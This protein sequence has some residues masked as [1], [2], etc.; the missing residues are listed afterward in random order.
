MGRN[1]TVIFGGLV[2]MLIGL[3]VLGIVVD[4]A[5]DTGAKA[6]IG[7]FTGV[8]S[9]ND[10]APLVFAIAVIVVGLVAMGLGGAGIAGY[11]PLKQR[12]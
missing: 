2:T 7:S 4:T 3:I 10:L 5:E 8:R 9:V 6:N 11:G 12:G 1:I